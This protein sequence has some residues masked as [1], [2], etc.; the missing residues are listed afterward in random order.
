MT[1]NK[2]H[3]IEVQ[4][5][6]KAYPTSEGKKSAVR[7]VSFTIEEGSLTV[8]GGEN[9]SGKSV[10][11]NIISGLEKQDSGTVSTIDRSDLFF[12]KQTHRF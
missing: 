6:S 1:D 8:I 7:D 11:M 2:K 5:V 10:L 12:R 9:G 3:A 4:N